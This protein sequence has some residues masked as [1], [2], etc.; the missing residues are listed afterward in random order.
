[1]IL[2][3]LLL[4]WVTAMTTTPLFCKTFLKTTKTSEG[5]SDQKDPY[6]GVVYRLYRAFLSFSIRLRWV[7]IAVVIG[8]FVLAMIGFGR[9]SNSFFPDSTSSQ[10]TIDFWL[11]EGTS[12]EET[13]RQ[14]QRVEAYLGEQE[15]V[16]S[17]AAFI[18]GGQIRFLLTYT[19][20]SQ[21][22]SYAQVLVKVD[23]YRKIP[24]IRPFPSGARRHRR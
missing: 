2:I 16:E 24:T 17:I 3:S 18:G 15:G 12:I 13:S 10:Y 21:Y 14:M 7:T 19:P 9:I 6:G 11:P 4:S 5:E 22:Y 23:D 8:L 20:E 1:V